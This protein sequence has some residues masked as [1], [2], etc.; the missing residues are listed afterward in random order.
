[1]KLRF[2]TGKIVDQD[3]HMVYDCKDKVDMQ[4]LCNDVNE[5]INDLQF[6]LDKKESTLERIEKVLERE[7]DYD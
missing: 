5:Q 2:E 1:M 7:R 3:Q 6:C 4:V